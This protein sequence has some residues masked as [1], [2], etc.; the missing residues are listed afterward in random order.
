MAASGR[1]AVS[2]QHYLRE[3]WRRCCAEIACDD[4]LPE[5]LGPT[6]A[7]GGML[8]E[9]TGAE[10]GV[11][12]V[13]LRRLRDVLVLSMLRAP[14]PNDAADPRGWPHWIGAGSS[15]CPRPLRR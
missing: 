5:D 8:A 4:E 6:A 3:L 12:Q 7:P 15:C 10:P 1:D 9:C 2:G 14:D 11:H 13:I